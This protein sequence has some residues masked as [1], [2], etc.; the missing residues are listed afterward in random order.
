MNNYELKTC[1][2]KKQW[3][4]FVSTSPQSAIHCTTPFLDSWGRDYELLLVTVKE[5]IQLGAVLVKQNGQTAKG[6]SMYHGVLFDISI[7][8]LPAHKRVKKSMSLIDFLLAELA[9]R[10]EE[11]VFSLH[12]SFE[13]LRSFQWFHYHEAGLGQFEINIAYTCVLSLSTVRDFDAI[14]MNA[15]AV[16]RQE[17]RRSLKEGYTVEESNDVNVLDYLHDLTF[18]RQGLKRND[19]EIFMTSRHAELAISDGFGRLLICRDKGQ[20][21]VSAVLFLYDCKCGYF[22]IGANHPEYRKSGTGTYT[23]F[24]QIQWCK[25]QGLLVV[26]LC[27]INSPNRGDFK[28]SFNAVPVPYY[29]VSWVRPEKSL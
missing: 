24:K 22:H 17:Y 28:T 29:T 6:P 13:D 19:G 21:P 15:R 25:E 18:K 1:E 16:R 23:L 7:A 10:Y 11:I 12:Y 27:G 26:D 4:S 3:N 5:R 20:N 9:L 14:L 2:D 8:N